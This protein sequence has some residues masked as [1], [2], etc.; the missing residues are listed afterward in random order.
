MTI[1]MRW[2]LAAGLSAIIIWALTII[3][4][5]VWQI[6]DDAYYAM[7]G[8]GYGLVD[9]PVIE[10][11][12]MHPLVARAV[13][14][15]H[16]LGAGF[17][18]A[19]FLYLCLWLGGTAVAYRFLECRG[20]VVASLCLAAGMTPVAL[21]PQYTA[22]AGFLVASAAVLWT[23]GRDGPPS[24]GTLAVGFALV[25]LASL[26]RI[27]MVALAAA[28]LAPVVL[29]DAYYSGWLNRTLAIKVALGAVAVLAGYHLTALGVGD[30]RMDEFYRLNGPVA[31]LLNYS[32]GA[33]LAYNE[34]PL[35]Q[36]FTAN[37]VRLLNN[38]FL[39]YSP[40]VEPAA[41][42]ELI[43]RVPFLEVLRLRYWVALDHARALPS[44][45][46]FWL[47]LASA[48]LAFLSRRRYAI[49]T[50]IALFA[51][52]WVALATL[53]KPP[54]ERVAM[55][56]AT[57]LFLLAALTRRAD[58]DHSHRAAWA[59]ALA[60]ALL[61]PVAWGLV[62]DRIDLA[63]QARQLDKDFP[64]LRGSDVVYV[65]VGNF[66]LRAGFR[67]FHTLGDVPPL[68]FMGSMYLLPQVTDG[69]RARGCGGFVKCLTSGVTVK[70]LASDEEVG[71]FD[72][73]LREHFGKKLMTLS[74]TETPSFTLH[75]ISAKDI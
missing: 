46:F 21:L 31:V 75:V 16:A 38:W 42:T 63:R 59:S 67:P 60:A 22:V 18:Y 27:Q 20:P 5:P 11:P 58:I 45:V 52:A 25:F 47:T 65:W 8:D 15:F 71:Q 35:P 70:L 33:T 48:V 3:V 1:G 74:R 57:G 14:A 72:T 56:I 7:L 73:L 51:L 39:A 17:G 62:A 30:P 61:L 4:Q 43:D 29:A 55:G 34:T 68:V 69:E 54:P 2:M 19:T 6:H 23:A 13:A 66:P 40:I 41:L 37:D 44:T 49:L 64:I 53:G 12:Y 32:F 50:A 10:I 24:L 28:C 9:R 36:G 26:L